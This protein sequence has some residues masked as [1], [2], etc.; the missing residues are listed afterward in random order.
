VDAK[1]QPLDAA[2]DPIQ[3]FWLTDST[4]ETRIRALQLGKPLAAIESAVERGH[5]FR[6]HFPL[7]PSTI[8]FIIDW[9]HS[10]V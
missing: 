5:E 2:L 1:K 3:K 10:P 9:N 4:P 7:K 8:S 6:N